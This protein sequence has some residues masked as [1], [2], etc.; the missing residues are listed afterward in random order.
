MRQLLRDANDKLLSLGLAD[1]V[2]MTSSDG[3]SL[4]PE[5]FSNEL[6]RLTGV[7]TIGLVANEEV[8]SS[9]PV[10]LSLVILN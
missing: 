6:E 8:Y 7:V 4:S 1:N 2:D 3:S 5:A 10:Q 9:G